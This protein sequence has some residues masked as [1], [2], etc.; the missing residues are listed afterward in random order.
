M[1]KFTKFTILIDYAHGEILNLTDNEFKL[2]N[3]LLI[4]RGYTS[5][6]NYSN[7]LNSEL[8]RDTDLLIIGCPVNSHLLKE[9]VHDIIDFVTAGGCLLVMSDYGGDIVQKTNLNE[10]TGY[11][12]IYFE[13]TA[14]K[15]TSNPGVY[16]K[17]APV[18]TEFNYDNEV[19]TKNVKKIIMGGCCSL[20]LGKEAFPIAFSG[21]NSWLEAY[22]NESNIWF[23]N[24][25]KNV[26]VIAA[27]IYGQG[28]VIA[29]GDIDM[30]SNNPL[31]GLNSL[32]NRRIIMNF[33]NW[34]QA[35]VS[36]ERTIFWIL[37][38]IS[39]K[40]DEIFEIKNVMHE[41]M[42]KMRNMEE[43]LITM[44][45]IQRQLQHELLNHL[46][47]HNR[48]FDGLSEESG[49]TGKKYEKARS[50]GT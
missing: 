16:T 23:R 15:S 8:L 43:R 22:D 13:N 48:E 4:D 7:K 18:I 14:V 33:L 29:I 6:I 26:P 37:E 36:Y 25:D 9:E 11:F 35:P 39:N 12:G 41:M 19:I 47:E 5:L 30:I 32:D 2:F 31:F 17:T 46:E 34:F 49:A 40:R 44:E 3:D 24:E 38:Q 42:E 45:T 21:P 27:A 1:P 50:H 20:R 10:L 28:R